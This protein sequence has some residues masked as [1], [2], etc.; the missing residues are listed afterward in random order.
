MEATADQVPAAHDTSAL[1]EELESL[2]RLHE[3]GILTDV[4]LEAAKARLLSGD[5]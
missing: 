3:R 1:L 5:K 4:E 2:V